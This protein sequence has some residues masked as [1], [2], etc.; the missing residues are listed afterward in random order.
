MNKTELVSKIAGRTGTTKKDTEAILNGFT[1]IVTE[2]L[3]YGEKIQLVGFGTF[4]TRMRKARQGI[5]P[6]NPEQ[7]I[8]IAASKAPAFKPG[9]AL[10][11]IVN[12]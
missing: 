10:K 6:K 1:E 11:E 2:S 7:K 9:K 12:K 3:A 8:S 5:N 4:E